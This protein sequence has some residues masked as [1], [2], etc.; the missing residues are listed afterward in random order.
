MHAIPEKLLG[1]HGKACACNSALTEL[2]ARAF[3]VLCMQIGGRVRAVHA[4]C[5]HAVHAIL[6]A[7]RADLA[8]VAGRRSYLYGGREKRSKN[9][10]LASMRN[11]IRVL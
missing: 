1:Q 5:M 11:Y 6:W 7:R 4:M 9:W 3:P 2:H 8:I 10:S